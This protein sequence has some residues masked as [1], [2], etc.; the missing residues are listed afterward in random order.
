MCTYSHLYHTLQIMSLVDVVQGTPEFFEAKRDTI[1]ASECATA[2]GFSHY[3]TPQD[4]L[5]RRRLGSDAEP[6][7]PNDAMKAGV[8]YESKIADEFAKQMGV[9]L[10]T[11]GM[12]IEQNI[13]WLSAAPDRSIVYGKP[14]WSYLLVEIKLRT[15][16][17][18]PDVPSI[19][20]IIQ[21]HHQLY[22]KGEY[23][24]HVFLVYSTTKLKLRIFLLRNH[25]IFY[26]NVI[27]P[28]LVEFHHC[29]KKDL[30]ASLSYQSQVH[31]WTEEKIKST[32]LFDI[33]DP[34]KPDEM[35]DK[36]DKP[37]YQYTQEE[38]TVAYYPPRQSW[39][40]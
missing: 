19:E 31:D 22:V 14:P 6:L 28:L 5:A 32:F 9:G 1:G 27:L 26:E 33:L 8:E 29:W 36:F 23:D 25:F 30:T 13:K 17:N 11:E 2:T 35:I 18:L 10:M 4:Y 39:S 7:E 3:C 37:G 24:R 21:V 16:D 38:I 34:S 40:I 12:W 20:H 15:H